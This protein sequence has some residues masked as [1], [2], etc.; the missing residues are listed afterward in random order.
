MRRSM[1]QS[2]GKAACL[3][4]GMV[5]TYGVL[6]TRGASTPSSRK[7]LVRRFRKRAVCCEPCCLSAYSTT[8]SRDSSHFSS[9]AP[10]DGGGTRDSGAEDFGSGFA[11]FTLLFKGSMTKVSGFARHVLVAVSQPVILI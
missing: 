5:L 4:G 2:P 8:P 1:S 11:G 9:A 10:F 7:R 3:S 6:T